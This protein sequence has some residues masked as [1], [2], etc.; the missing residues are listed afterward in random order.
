MR[1]NRAAHV[2]WAIF[3]LLATAA[4][5]FFYAA[6]FHPARVPVRFRPFGEIPPDHATIGGTPLGL[7]LGSA[8]LAIFIFAAL[9]GMRKRLPTW[10]IGHVQ[11]WLRGHI[12]LTIL[13]VPL[14]LLH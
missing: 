9:L 7:I 14:I 13:T 11:T 8:A 3:V 4:A 2:P 10:R 1:I 5:S 12:S 6:K